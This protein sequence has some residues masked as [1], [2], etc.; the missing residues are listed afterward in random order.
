VIR[1]WGLGALA[2]TIELIVS[3]LVTNAVAASQ[4][5]T[6]SRYLGHWV[7]GRPPVR[8]WL[9]SERQHVLIQVWDGNDRTPVRQEPGLDEEHGRGLLLI[10]TLCAKWGIYTPEQSSGKVVWAAC[11]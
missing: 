3:E 5:L 11:T 4:D 9:Q 10:E 2:E 6:A 1:E 8:L 7:P